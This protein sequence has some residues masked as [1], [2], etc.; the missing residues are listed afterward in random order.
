MT[1]NW[2]D[3]N[4]RLRR[5][6]KSSGLASVLEVAFL[7]SALVAIAVG[8]KPHPFWAGCDWWKFCEIFDE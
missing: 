1:L 4:E 6:V 8:D 7:L 3:K 5:N 2:I